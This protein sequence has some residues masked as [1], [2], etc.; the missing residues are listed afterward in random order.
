MHQLL[1]GELQGQ[2]WSYL[3][4]K[5]CKVFSAPFDVRLSLP[6]GQQTSD[7]LDTVVQPDMCVVCDARKLDR[8]GCQGPPDWVIEILSPST[9]HKDLHE[10]FTLYQHAGVSEYWVVFPFERALAVYH[11]NE[12]GLY[13]ALQPQPFAAP[14]VVTSLT[15]PELS[16]DLGELFAELDEGDFYPG[17]SLLIFLLQK[18]FPYAFGHLPVQSRRHPNR[19]LVPSQ[20]IH[21]SRRIGGF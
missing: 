12:E 11:L 17:G 3:R 8:R 16:I 20:S 13:Q 15:F 19:S 7:K 5:A 14:K 18:Y 10:K 1:S 9:T 21:A 6:P 4:K 2:I